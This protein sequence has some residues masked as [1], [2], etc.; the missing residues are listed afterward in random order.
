MS[1]SLSRVTADFAIPQ[2]FPGESID[3]PLI[4]TVSQ[5]AEALGYE[6]VWALDQVLGRA[7][8]LEPVSLLAFLAGVTRRVRLGVSVLVLPFRNPLVLAK[9]LTTVDVLSGGRLTVGVGLGAGGQEAAFG[10]PPGRRVRRF[11]EQLQVM[12]ALWQEESVRSNGEFF[13]L[14][15]VAMEPKPVQRP[16][17]PLWFGGKAEAALQRAVRFGDG[18]MGAGSS[19]TAEFRRSVVR[20]RFFLEQADRDPETFTIS[21]RVYVAIDENRDRAQRRLHGWF[22]WVYGS[23]DMGSEVAIWGPV[24][25]CVEGIDEII[26]AGAQHLVLNPMFDYIEHLEALSP[27]GRLPVE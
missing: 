14:A 20:V 24:E 26:D 13:Q 11:V 25:A 21:K 7:P 22:G 10:L 23:P 18:W 4:T 5:R 2:I 9:A 8:S 15:D 16:R 1:A 6:G 17:P 19:S 27:Y 3:L 12:E